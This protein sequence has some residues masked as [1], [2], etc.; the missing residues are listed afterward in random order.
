MSHRQTTVRNASLALFLLAAVALP[1]IRKRS[2]KN[3]RAAADSFQTKIDH[4]KANAAAP[5]VDPAPTRFSQEEINAYF[6]ERRLNMPE[7]V[8]S[9]VFD[10]KPNQVSAVTRV[11]FAQIRKGRGT[12]N[13]LLAIFDGI[14]D[15][16]VVASTEAAAPGTVHVRVETVEIDGLTVPNM[17]LEMFVKHYV[18]P[19]YP[20]VGLDRDYRLPARIDSAAIGDQIGTI[21]QK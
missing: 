11:D 12:M 4:I 14:H 5:N 8:K 10:L 13:P 3:D 16:H 20:N 9:V 2:F 6:S 21:T 7:G 15:C 17:A 18:N 1:V 19:R